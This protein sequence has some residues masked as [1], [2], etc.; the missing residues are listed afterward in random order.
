MPRRVRVGLLSSL[1][2][3][4]L[5]F[6]ASAARGVLYL[7]TYVRRVWVGC[8]TLRAVTYVLRAMAGVFQFFWR[9]EGNPCEARSTRS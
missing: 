4:L 5:Y 9:G 2:L 1:S 7:P 6:S 3:L 8:V